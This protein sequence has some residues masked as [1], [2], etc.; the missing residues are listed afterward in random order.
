[1]IHIKTFEEIAIMTD[2]ATAAMSYLTDCDWNIDASLGNC[3]FFAKDFYEWCHR[4]GIDC[5]LAYLKQ[6][7]SF[8]TGE[9]EDHIVPI[10]AGKMIDFVYTDY[11]VS[12][13]ARLSNK[14]ESLRRQSNPEITDIRDFEKKYSKWGYRQIEEIAYEEAY[15]GESAI[16]QTI[17]YPERIDEDIKIPINVGDTILGGRF[18]NKKTIVKKIGKNAKGD[19]TVNG[20]PLLKYRLVKE[21]IESFEEDTIELLLPIRDMGLNIQ[22]L[23]GDGPGITGMTRIFGTDKKNPGSDTYNFDSDSFDWKD[24][25]ADVQLY[26]SYMTEEHGYDFHVAYYIGDNSHHTNGYQRLQIEQEDILEG[27]I[28]EKIKMIAIGFKK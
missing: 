23:S 7:E 2:S 21:S 8:A 5:T 24:I 20:K 28:P 16:C 13:R 12:R 17:E 4:E 11:G 18:K 9:I 25:E 10:V 15:E 3:A 14:E 1:M 27:R 26:V 6:D 19:I 22:I